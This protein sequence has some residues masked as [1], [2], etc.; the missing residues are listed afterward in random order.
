M[1]DAR[2][3]AVLFR[4]ATGHGRQVLAPPVFMPMLASRPASSAEVQEEPHNFLRAY[5]PRRDIEKIATATAVT[6]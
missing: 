6:T 2:D 1:I 4:A 5:P 3:S